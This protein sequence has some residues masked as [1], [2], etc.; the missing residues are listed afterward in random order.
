VKVLLAAR[1]VFSVS[2]ESDLGQLD[3][4]QAKIGTDL[5]DFG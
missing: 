4:L 3:V 2:A 1:E 5:P